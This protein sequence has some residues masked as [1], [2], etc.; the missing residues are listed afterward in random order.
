MNN[1]ALFTDDPAPEQDNLFT[2]KP[3]P[4]SAKWSDLLG[5]IIPDA[6]SVGKGLLGASPPAQQLLNIPKYAQDAAESSQEMLGGKD[7]SSTPEA[8]DIKNVG[9]SVLD[10]A[11]SIPESIMNLGSKSEWVQH[12]VQNAIT[13]GGLLE[14]GVEGAL[15]AEPATGAT[16]FL[17]D[18]MEKSGAREATAPSVAG[19]SA[20]TIERMTP[21]GENP[22]VTRVNAGKRLI[23]EGVVGRGST[24]ESISNEQIKMQK[25]Y[26]NKVKDILGQIRDSGIN[27]E[28]KAD[29]AL[30][31][32]LDEW[33]KL[34]DGA[35]P[36][37][38]AMSKTF[39]SVYTKLEDVANKNNGNLKFDD[40]HSLMHEVGERIKETPK[41]SPRLPEL[42]RL[43]KTLAR[44]S[45]SIVN[46]VG[47]R[48]GNPALAN[49]LKEANKGFHFY[50]QINKDI[51]K[52]AAKEGVEKASQLGFYGALWALSHGEL[53]KAA[54]YF[55]GGRLL[56]PAL[57]EVSP[58]MAKNMLRTGETISKYGPVLENAAKKGGRNLAMTSYLLSQK[59]PDY[60]DTLSSLSKVGV[61]G[62]DQ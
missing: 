48:S 28:T 32:I 54:E 11:K 35:L 45:E 50:S 57:K 10:Y 43:Y 15:K 47:E 9:S 39:A 42:N 22:A 12:P 40:I 1:D 4:E 38:R 5:N 41:E 31:P 56:G 46:D 21:I 52:T 26:G 25:D 53:D 7:F 2:D 29:K 20:K 14:G 13:A 62:S 19:L 24:A 44:S 37:S 59:D 55:V 17:G 51:R 6:E 61:T 34:A 30:S 60:A 23:N 49:Q 58:S 8:Q 36:A 27:P 18:V 16:G 33:A 3:A